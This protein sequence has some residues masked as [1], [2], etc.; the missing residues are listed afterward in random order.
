MLIFLFSL[1]KFTIFLSTC[2][3]VFIFALYFLIRLAANSSPFSY[4]FFMWDTET[5]DMHIFLAISLCDISVFRSN[6]EIADFLGV[7]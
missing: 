4:F 5:Y 6:A 3:K 7:K 1:Q 2:S